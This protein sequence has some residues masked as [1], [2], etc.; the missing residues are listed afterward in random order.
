M[1]SVG[2]RG[3]SNCQ[4]ALGAATLG[5]VPPPCGGNFTAWPSPAQ[6]VGE[7]GQRPDE[8][9]FFSRVQAFEPVSGSPH[10][11]CRA[12]SPMQG[13][14]RGRMLQAGAQQSQIQLSMS[15]GQSFA[16]GG[17]GYAVSGWC[18]RRRRVAW[19]Q[20]LAECRS[21]GPAVWRLLAPTL[22]WRFLPWVCSDRALD[23][24]VSVFTARVVLPL[25]ARGP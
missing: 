15:I 17:N 21:C 4:S 11:P 9:P 7:G 24:T 12:P 23:R 19:A 1:V 25:K 13:H 22:L 2:L 3:V 18:G 10:P 6:R 16:G 20:T 14:G 8:G 5:I